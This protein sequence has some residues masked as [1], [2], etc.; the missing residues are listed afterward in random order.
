MPTTAEIAALAQ[1]RAQLLEQVRPDAS[2]RPVAVAPRA[3]GTWSDLAPDAPQRGHW[4]GRDFMLRTTTLAATGRHEAAISALNWWIKNDPLN[5]NWWHNQI[6]TPRLIGETLLLLGD[7][8]PAGMAE[9]CRHIFGR[10]GEF[11]LDPDGINRSPKIWTGANRIWLSIN[12]LFAAVLL[13]EP[14]QIAPAVA[15][16]MEEVRIAPA[17]EEGMQV[18]GSFHQHGPLLYNGGY[19]RAFLNDC[20][21]IISATRGTPWAPAMEIQH[22]LIDHLLDGTRWMLRGDGVNPSSCDRN[23]T[24]DERHN[25][26]DFARIGRIL[27][28]D[29]EYRHDELNAL[30]EA[31]DQHRSPGKII[32]NRLFYRSDFM[33]QQSAAVAVSVRM[34]SVR[35]KRAECVNNEGRRSHHLADGLTYLLRDGT[36]YHG[37]FP[38]WD[39][40]KLPGITCVQTPAP[41]PQ[42][43]VATD[44]TATAV[45]GVSDG[46]YGACTQHLQSDL[47]SIRKSWFFGPDTTV[48]L[49]AGLES[50]AAPI[51]TTLDQSL[52]Q[53]PVEYDRSGTP[54]DFGHHELTDL[55]WLSHGPWKFIFPQPVN[56]TLELGP[57]TGT[58]SDIG[59]HA[60]APVAQDVFLAYLTHGPD[61]QTDGYAYAIL[62]TNDA[63]AEFV[64][65]QN[66]AKI[67]AVWW[68]SINLLQA[69]FHEAGE[70]RFSGGLML[71]MNRESCVQLKQG[72]DGQWQLVAGDITQRGGL[73]SAELRDEHGQMIA[74]GSVQAPAGDHAGRSVRIF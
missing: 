1:A 62:N 65:V 17:T 64:I 45:G 7:H 23:I 36:E 19:G 30:A 56:L 12:R 10:A 8:A 4:D 50:N 27:G 25:N 67:Q 47:L 26:E 5:P 49:G 70:L 61:K 2:A 72:A 34:H 57:R 6:G 16:A 38:V 31:I 40:Q 28:S 18:D 73:I 74:K 24:R 15:A 35:T 11:L 55:K 66:S 68:P 69:A 54:L 51:V 42:H 63:D 21:W 37:I 46:Q 60:N 9:S 29:T 58:W 20:C 44:S 14:G 22:L 53:G 13:N 59:T 71:C 41:E 3:D 52:I 33:V 48:C 43:T 32:G 39:W